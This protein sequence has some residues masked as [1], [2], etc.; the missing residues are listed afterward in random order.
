[1]PGADSTPATLPLPTGGQP[2]ALR[3]ANRLKVFISYSRSDGAFAD[4]LVRGLEYDGDFEVS[5]DRTAIHE[6]E[7]WKARLGALIAAAD[8]V[9]F[10]LSPKSAASPVCLWEVEEAAKLSKRII[11]VQALPLIGTRPPE[12]LAAL[13]YVRFD[14][15]DTGH[16]R[17]FMSGLA[18]LRRAL[19]TDIAW[20]RE[21]TRLLVR[22]REWDGAGRPENR[23]LI[24]PDIKAAERWLDGRPAEAPEATELHR[25]FITASATSEAQRQSVERARANRLQ[26]AVTWTRLALAGAT[27]LAVV[28]GG[29]G[30]W[31]WQNKLVADA[32]KEKTE[33]ALGKASELLD[34]LLPRIPVSWPADD[35]NSPDYRHL[36][37]TPLGRET[38][39][40]T[41]DL[42]APAL[43]LLLSSNAF[44]P[45]R[46]NDNV[47]VALRG[48]AL[49]GGAIHRDVTALRLVEKRP[50]HSAFDSVFVVWHR[51]SGR[52]SGFVGS[53]VPNHKF[54]ANA[55]RSYFGET[56]SVGAHILSTGAY[57]YRIGQHGGGR[58]RGAFRLGATP[59]EDG[60]PVAVR[61]TYN[62]L[63]Y[64]VTDRWDVA[65]T[66]TNLHPAYA[67]DAFSSAGSLTIRGPVADGRP[68]AD[69]A[70]F[71]GALGLDPTNPPAADNDKP[72]TIVILTGLDAAVASALLARGGVPSPADRATYLVR[73]RQGSRSDAVAKLQ[74]ALGVA[75]TGSFGP[76][77]TAALGKRQFEALKWS[78]GIYSSEMDR[79]LGLCVLRGTDCKP[80]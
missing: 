64:D 33:E 19:T 35:M 77:T 70:Q 57:G 28:A 51:P 48:A 75:P 12:R 52:L 36:A 74:A 4:E 30:W 17:S 79:L 65:V 73:L 2:V 27:A 53:T 62:D 78:D 32:E 58:I 59:A 45:I 68:A 47:V 29:A 10:V 9:V 44:D 37:V 3:P 55:F 71:R 49:A 18:G 61:R 43:E 31:A 67:M 60:G 24:G 25:D 11:P 22:A 56:S 66:F 6:G 34:L 16:P 72:V 20:L 50:D 13:N 69:F 15:D 23:L 54:I 38:R 26:R 21:H 1:M 42:E 7:D 14:P 76:Q 80:K 5:I 40:T 8:T 41:F 46:L 63:T 39:G